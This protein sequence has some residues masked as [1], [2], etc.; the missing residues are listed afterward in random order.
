[1]SK[2]RIVIIDYGSGNIRSAAKAFL[3]YVE[4]PLVQENLHNNYATSC[5]C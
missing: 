1:M 2:E 5:E 3:F 4:T